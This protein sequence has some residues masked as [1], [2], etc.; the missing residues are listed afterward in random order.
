LWALCAFGL[1]FAVVVVV[2]AGWMADVL[3]SVAALW[4]EVVEEAPQA[5]TSNESRTAAS[6]MRR[7]LMAVSRPPVWW[8]VL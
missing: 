7:C 5:L 1:A 8:L 6:G 4:L 2:G 3:V